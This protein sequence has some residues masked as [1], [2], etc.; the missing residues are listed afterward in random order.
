M[1]R[2][3]CQILLYK[4][5]EYKQR[6]KKIGGTKMRESFKV[7]SEEYRTLNTL[8]E[9]RQKIQNK[10]QLTDD[11]LCFILPKE[12]ASLL[13]SAKL[14]EQDLNK[15]NM[16]YQRKVQLRRNETQIKQLTREKEFKQ[17]QVNKKSLVEA[18]EGFKDKIKPSYFLMNE[19]DQIL[20]KI[21][22]IQE[23]NINIK[24]DMKK[25]VH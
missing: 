17:E 3:R 14:R 25:D 22:E 1:G 16:E 9:I 12:E 21:D 18:H 8:R 10:E 15:E 5:V 7:N 23:Q 4:G 11:E 24:K 13:K 6:N 19:I 2:G 20:L